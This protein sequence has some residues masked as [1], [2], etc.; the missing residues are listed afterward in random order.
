MKLITSKKYILFIISTLILSLLFFTMHSFYNNE[1]KT[2]KNRDLPGFYDINFENIFSKDDNLI[3]KDVQVIIKD[4]FKKFWI[5]NQLSGGVLVA[6]GNVIIFENYIGFSNF[7]KQIPLTTKTAIQT[8]SI[9]KNLTAMA[10]LKLVEAEKIKLSDQ[11][12]K[13]LKQFPYDNITIIDLL[14][15]RSGLSEYGYFAEQDGIW[16][17]DEDY[18]SNQKVLELYAK[19]Q[20]EPYSLP[21]KNFSYCNTN[22]VFLALIIEKI[23]GKKYPLAMKQMVFDPL[24]MKNTYVFEKHHFNSA[25]LSYFNNGKLHPWDFRDLVYGDKNIYST[26]RDL[27]KYSQAMFSDSF[28]RQTLKDSAMMGYSNERKGMKNYGLG[29]RIYQF[30][31]GKKITYHN[32]WWHGNNTTFVH[33]PDEKVTIIALGNKKSRN[34]YSAFTLSGLFGDYGVSMAIEDHSKDNKNDSLYVN[35]N[36]SIEKFKKHK[37]EKSSSA[38]DIENNKIKD[39]ILD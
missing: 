36:H 12:K 9:T 29:F 39:T 10:I 18:L 7:E 38:H 4:Y 31:N 24:G 33:L 30:N 15:H 22:Y 34:I 23:T 2:P 8:A 28:L 16:N 1:P 6:K 5:D 27:L 37:K 14:N 25:S 19:H 26:P 13:H 21:N 3:D 11:V 32:G 17:K 20:P 35:F